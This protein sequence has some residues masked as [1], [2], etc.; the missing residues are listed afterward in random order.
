MYLTIAIVFFR[1]WD[2]SEV[3]ECQ[4][5]IDKTTIIRQS[6]CKKVQCQTFPSS[7]S[8]KNPRFNKLRPYLSGNLGNFLEKI[9]GFLR[10]SRMDDT[11]KEP[12]TKDPFF[13]GV[14]CRQDFFPWQKKNMSFESLESASPKIAGLSIVSVS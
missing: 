2:G 6:V 3:A 7:R 9:K 12:L 10:C 5:E 11:A 14:I 8:E 13:V 4:V 1:Q